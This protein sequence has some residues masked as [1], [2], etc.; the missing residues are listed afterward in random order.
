MGGG[1]L[2]QR[3]E[4]R[5]MDAFEIFQNLVVP[6][7]QNSIALVLQKQTPLRLVGRRTIVMAAVDLHDQPGFVADKVGDVWADRDLTAEL[8][9]GHLL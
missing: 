6:K 5:S 4:E 8:M 3:G 7:S 1:E 9:A 2:M